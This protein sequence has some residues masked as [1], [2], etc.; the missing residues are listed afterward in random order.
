MSKS[1]KSRSRRVLVGECSDSRMD[2]LLT[3][4]PAKATIGKLSVTDLGVSHSLF[5]M[6]F[7]YIEEVTKEESRTVETHYL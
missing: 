6:A 3:V 7:E 5:S 4:H 2:M 1:L